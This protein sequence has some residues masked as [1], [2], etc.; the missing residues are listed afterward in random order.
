MKH[1]MNSSWI[2]K[3]YAFIENNN[4]KEEAKKEIMLGI[5]DGTI[6]MYTEMYK[7]FHFYEC[8][9]ISIYTVSVIVAF[10]SQAGPQWFDEEPQH[11]LSHDMDEYSH[12]KEHQ[13]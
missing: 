2:N 10:S 11:H 4:K 1:S 9:F 12:C 6:V 7:T 13:I 3:C 5:N 8:Y